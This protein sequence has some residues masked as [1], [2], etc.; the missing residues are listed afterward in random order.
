M[1]TSVRDEM[2]KSS[3]IFRGP[4]RA[5]FLGYGAP[6]PSPPRPKSL[7]PKMTCTI[8]LSIESARKQS[9]ASATESDAEWLLA[10]SSGSILVRWW[11]SEW[12]RRDAGI[13]FSE[14]VHLS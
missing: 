1:F 6:D 8:R 5:L 11:R 12:S 4:T 10:E 3:V 9:E 14:L 7:D 13:S 2:V